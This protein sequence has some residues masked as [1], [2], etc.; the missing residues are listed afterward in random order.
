MGAGEPALNAYDFFNTVAAK[1]VYSDQDKSDMLA[2]LL[3]LDVL[4]VTLR[5]E[6]G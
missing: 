4:L 5:T 3:T 2:A 6:C 1:T